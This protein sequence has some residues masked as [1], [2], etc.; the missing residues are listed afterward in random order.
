MALTA[1]ARAVPWLSW[2]TSVNTALAISSPD[3]L[4]LSL[5]QHG[6]HDRSRDHHAGDPIRN[7][8]RDEAEAQELDDHRADKR[9]QNGG[10]PASKGSASNGYGRDGIE[11][12]VFS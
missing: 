11:L 4:P 8:V 3:G 10:A 12:H 1:R 5:R 9:A 7:V 6:D 2:T